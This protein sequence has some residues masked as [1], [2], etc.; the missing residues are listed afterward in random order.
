[1]QRNIHS[2]VFSVIVEMLSQ[3]TIDRSLAYDSVKE[4]TSISRK[5]AWVQRYLSDSEDHY[6][7]RIV[8]LAVYANVFLSSTN[9]LL[10]YLTQSEECFLPGVVRSIA[11][12]FRDHQLYT[13]FYKAVFRTLQNRP[14]T[15]LIHQMTRDAVAV[16]HA[17]VDDLFAFHKS[18]TI[19]GIEI[20]PANVK[21]YV[22]TVANNCLSTFEIKKVFPN[23]NS[24]ENM[25]W[26]GKTLEEEIRMDENEMSG[27]VG[28]VDHPNLPSSIK[29]NLRQEF[30]LMD[31]F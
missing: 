10:L 20:F 5:R 26:V 21:K 9:A 3:E 12:I 14:T 19:A 29:I 28:V 8:A 7:F 11:K 6:C 2:E 16:E 1:M 23:D 31:D 13:D 15:I 4:F 18:Y 30:S 27:P 24:E 17:L 22:E 25:S